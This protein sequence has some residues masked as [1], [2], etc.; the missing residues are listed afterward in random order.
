MKCTSC[1]LLGWLFV[2]LGSAGA[3][4]VLS[5]PAWL[6]RGTYFDQES[7][8]EVKQESQALDPERLKK[9]HK[10]LDLVFQ[11][12]L[13][14]YKDLP[15]LLESIPQAVRHKVNHNS[16]K[17]SEVDRLLV[18]LVL[19]AKSNRPEQTEV[20]AKN[21]LNAYPDGK[22]RHLAW[23]YQVQSAFVQLKPLPFD[24]ALHDL[25]LQYLSANRKQTYVQF[26]IDASL[27]Q[28]SFAE[29]L[30]WTLIKAA[31]FPKQDVK[32]R[33]AAAVIIK[34]ISNEEVL[35]RLQNNYRQP[36]W[37][38][39]DLAYRRLQII[40]G[41]S[42][43]NQAKQMVGPLMDQ[44]WKR[45]DAERM[46]ALVQM[47]RRIKIAAEVKPLR[48]G[49]LLPL[50][51]G[52]LVVA[53]LTQQVT[54]GLQLALKLEP[55]TTAVFELPEEMRGQ[56]P[57]KV[58]GEVP[59]VE[60]VFRDTEL[61]AAKTTAAVRELVEEQ[62]VI[63]I[64]GPLI[65][66]TSE[67]AAAEAQRLQV[68]LISL[69]QTQSI[70]QVGDYVF[71]NNHTWQ[72]QMKQLAR[73]VVNRMGIREVAIVYPDSRDGKEKM[74]GFWDALEAEGGEVHAV[75]SFEHGL[76]NFTDLFTSLT[77]RNR[78]L[79]Y[80]TR[81][82]LEKMDE[83]PDS[84]ADFQALFIPV[85]QREISDLKVL[86]PYRP[87]FGLSQKQLLG[88]T[89]WTEFSVVLTLEDEPLDPLLVTPFYKQSPHNHIRQFVQA[90]QQYYFT[91]INYLGPT[92]Y[93]AFAFDTVQLLRLQLADKNHHSHESLRNSLQQMAPY[94]GV[95][96]ALTFSAD[97]DVIRQL[98]LLKIHA[99][100]LVSLD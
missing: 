5:D 76:K 3:Q 18:E 22:Y 62:H 32:T 46:D 14:E 88:D 37:V 35:S 24:K 97:G 42:D 67:A 79:S 43:L 96:G 25:A 33:A 100:Q 58:V 44:A 71:R 31:L 81:V 85:S 82:F 78:Y 7:Q 21:F 34:Q 53:R 11:Q 17:L 77:G 59:Q 65:R 50:T 30:E 39:Y 89:S 36:E 70:S 87:V 45:Q 80:S 8:T 28:E 72:Q 41:R 83:E 1:L 4:S 13:V 54:E 49:V 26:Y 27:Q 12:N 38:P 74:G 15:V 55:N 90:H 61:N 92:D 91:P 40:L 57:R 52:H 69:S 47:L 48:V 9:L 10:L 86:L 73:H 16:G 29:A 6:E 51:S 99:N 68:P 60:L 20:L 75:E 19:A 98:N 63:A 66:R 95:T 64:V 84:I 23:F 56:A 93:T 94:H 2:L